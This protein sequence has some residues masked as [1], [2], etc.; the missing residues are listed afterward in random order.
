MVTYDG[1]V[2]FEVD[3]PKGMLGPLFGLTVGSLGFATCLFFFYVRYWKWR[4]CFNELG[5]CYDPDGSMQVYTTA[6]VSW[7]LLS[8]PFLVVTLVSMWVL[9][10]RRRGPGPGL[11]IED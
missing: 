9:L 2:V 5:R 4:D 8:V 11:R 7:G 10:R 6:G 3:P 1:R